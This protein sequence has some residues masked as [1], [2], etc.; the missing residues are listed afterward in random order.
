MQTFWTLMTSP[1]LTLLTF[2]PV[3]ACVPLLFFPREAQYS[4]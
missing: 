4:T 3:A 2:F 1:S